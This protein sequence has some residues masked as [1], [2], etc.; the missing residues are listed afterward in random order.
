MNCEDIGIKLA[1]ISNREDD[2]FNEIVIS[3]EPDKDKVENYFEE[4]VIPDKPE[5]KNVKMVHLPYKTE[6]KTYRQIPYVSGASGSGKSYYC[7]IYC[8]E[9]IKL[10]PKN[11]IYL[12]S[13]LTE[14]ATLDKLG[15]KLNRVKLDEKFYNTQFNI[16]SFKDCLI[17]FDDTET[18]KNILIR[19]KL[20]NIMDLILETGRHTSTFCIITSH[21][22]VNRERTKLILTEAHSATIFPATIGG[23]TLKYLL[24]GYF[25]LNKEQI[26]KI[27]GLQSRW[28]TIV[29]TYPMIVLYEKGMYV[30][31]K[32]KTV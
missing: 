16:Q 26:Q 4:I 8:E 6:D 24:D 31:N 2:K 5:F 27:E 10:F 9:Y 12:F 21:I 14:D 1:K 20:K 28:I 25:G 15:K 32:K 29:K 7:L 11:K 18:I 22:T 30:L 19:E 23:R 3:V 13:S 17:I